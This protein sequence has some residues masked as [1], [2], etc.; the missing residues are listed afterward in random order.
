MIE[1]RAV[2]IYLPM[3]AVYLIY[4]ANKSNDVPKS[5]QEPESITTDTKTL[6][7]EL[8]RLTQQ[9]TDLQQFMFDTEQEKD[10]TYSISYKTADNT[11]KTAEIIKAVD[12]TPYIRELAQQQITATESRIQDIIQQLNAPLTHEETATEKAVYVADTKISRTMQYISRTLKKRKSG[13]SKKR[14]GEN[15]V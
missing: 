13:D 12:S 1:W 8:H 11:T 6:I 14:Q 5:E 15:N 7:E 10:T 9:H 2:F 4:L 3:L